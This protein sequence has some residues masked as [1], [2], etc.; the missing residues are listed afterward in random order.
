MKLTSQQSET[1]ASTTS[2]LAP[3]SYPIAD[4][5]ELRAAE[6]PFAGVDGDSLKFPSLE[7]ASPQVLPLRKAAGAE[8]MSAHAIGS[9]QLQ[10]QLEG[11]RLSPEASINLTGAGA[12]SLRFPTGLG[13][14]SSAARANGP[15]IGATVPAL[16]TSD[17]VEISQAAQ[18]LAALKSATSS[19]IIDVLN[20]RAANESAVERR[21]LYAQQML[22]PAG[23]PPP[24]PLP[25]LTGSPERGIQIAAISHSDGSPSEQGRDE[26]RRSDQEDAA[27]HHFSS[28]AAARDSKIILPATL[29]SGDSALDSHVIERASAAASSVL[30][31]ME[32]KGLT[33][34]PANAKTLVALWQNCFK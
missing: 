27:R 2:H 1:T 33:I 11:V 32:Q 8:S 9:M 15:T 24:L 22:I 6:S 18:A 5:A 20:Q 12:T 21:R 23:L 29:M 13:A 10:S 25:P 16:T 30:W 3:E 17:R 19:E 14:I 7:P 26:R 4:Y 31:E 34:E 28:K